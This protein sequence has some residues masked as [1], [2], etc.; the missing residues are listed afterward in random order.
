MARGASRQELGPL[1]M[2]SVAARLPE[3]AHVLSARRAKKSLGASTRVNFIILGDG[4]CGLEALSFRLIGTNGDKWCHEFFH[5][6]HCVKSTVNEALEWKWYF[7]W[8]VGNGI[9]SQMKRETQIEISK[10]CKS[11]TNIFRVC[12]NLTR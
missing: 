7:N 9:F 5:C 10:I 12:K 1:V 4:E 6:L 11:A 8:V 3:A 2:G